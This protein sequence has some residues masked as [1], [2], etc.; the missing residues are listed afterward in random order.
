MNLPVYEPYRHFDY[1][2]EGAILGA[3]LLEKFAISRILSVIEDES[4]FYNE[5]NRIVFKAMLA[6]LDESMPIDIFTVSQFIV[7]RMKIRELGEGNVAYYL[8]KLTNAVVSTANLEVHAFLLLECWKQ[9]KLVEIKYGAIDSD[10]S[11]GENIDSITESLNKVM[12]SKMSADWLPMDELLI[13][14]YQHQEEMREAK[15]IGLLTGIS[16]IDKN[17]GFFAPNYIFLGARPGV[18]KSAF[19]NSIA[20]NI[21]KQNKTVGIISLEMGNVEIAARLAAIDTKTDFSFIFRGLMNDEKEMHRV[22]ETLNNQTAGL[23]I[24][25]SDKTGV[26]ISE[27]RRRAEVLKHRKNVDLL[28]IDYLQLVDSANSKS[29]T[30]ENEIAIISRGIKLLAKDLN[31]PILILGQLNRESTKRT[32]E[33]RYPVLGDIRESGSIEQDADIVFFLH[34]DYLS[35]VTEDREGRST[36]GYVELINRKWRN[37]KLGETKKLRFNGKLMQFTDMDESE[38]FLAPKGFVKVEDKVRQFDDD[39]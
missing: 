10:L 23:P 28:I 8:V 29:G 21:A 36:E 15:G 37:F 33:H 20:V 30:R 22:Y 25:V 1:N 38:Q 34:S 19:A 9:R 35:G 32:G 17:G 3:C 2:L 5:A 6:M 7:N 13:Q 18:G 4:I 16:S 12:R 14:L 27:I 39:F 11:A 31:I 24:Y 26:T